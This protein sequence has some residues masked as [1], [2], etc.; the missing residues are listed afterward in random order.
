MI[1]DQLSILSH[2][3]RRRLLQELYEHGPGAELTVPDDILGDDE[4]ETRVGTGLTHVHLPKLEDE[5][6]IQW[7][8]DD[9]TVTRGVDFDDIAPLLELFDEHADDLPYEWP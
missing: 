7:D 9:G 1:G 5:D 8:R 4:D 6:L 2:P 3:L